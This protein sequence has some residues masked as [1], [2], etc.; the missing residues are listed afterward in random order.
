MQLVRRSEQIAGTA[1]VNFFTVFVIRTHTHT[2]HG[3]SG[4]QGEGGGGQSCFR[5]MR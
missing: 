3:E 4:G 5:A 1:A 2:T